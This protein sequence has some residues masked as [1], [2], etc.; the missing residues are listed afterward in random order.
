MYTTK[1]LVF[2]SQIALAAACF[3]LA[4]CA[5]TTSLDQNF[6]SSYQGFEQES[7]FDGATSFTGDIGKLE[8]Y[9]R[10]YIER[11]KVSSPNPEAKSGFVPAMGA[12]EDSVTNDVAPEELRKLEGAFRAAL[13]KELGAN[14]TIVSSP[15]PQTISV[16]AA[17]VDLQPGNPLL[18]ASSYAPYASTVATASSLMTGTSLGAGDATIEAELLDSTTR[19]RFFGII[20]RAAG[21]KFRPREGLSRWGQVELMF[22]KWSK[23]FNVVIQGKT[24]DVG[25]TAKAKGV[26]G[27][28]AETTKGLA[29]DATEK[30]KELM[31]GAAEKSKEMM[32]GAAEK[33]KALPGAGFFTR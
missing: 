14:Y 20:D 3:I 5:A 8:N 26:A 23:E 28:A 19:E 32:G 25:L 17:V 6:L 9:K 18:F 11:V 21:S 15:G 31:G 7:R 29:G 13:T 27:D 12:V 33:A 22:E 16:R 24:R 10:V 4:G 2:P 1:T 30:S